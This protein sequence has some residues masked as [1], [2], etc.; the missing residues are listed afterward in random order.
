MARDMRD[1]M[2]FAGGLL[3]GFLVTLFGVFA[4]LPCPCW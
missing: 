2:W 4:P 1:V 3:A